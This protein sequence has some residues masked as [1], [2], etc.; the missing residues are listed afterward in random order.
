MEQRTG[1]V[2]VKGGGISADQHFAAFNLDFA[3]RICVSTDGAL[4]SDGKSLRVSGATDATVV[5]SCDTNWRFDPEIMLEGVCKRDPQ[6]R[7]RVDGTADAAL[8]R[9]YAL[10]RKRHLDD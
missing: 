5:L 9:G 2:A 7:R 10:L 4:A 3:A 6:L 8:S 1:S